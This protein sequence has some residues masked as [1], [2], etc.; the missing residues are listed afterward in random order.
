[1][2]QTRIIIWEGRSIRLSYTPRYCDAIDHV[3]IT[4]EDRQPLP[5]TETGY[6]SHFFGPV[7]PALTIDDV[8]H[9]VVAWLDGE[10]KGKSWQDYVCR[11][12]QLS[13]F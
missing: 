10:A 12:R 5:V 13:L 7:T 11:A 3:E 9:M 4:A 2:A 1:M 6:R 8:E